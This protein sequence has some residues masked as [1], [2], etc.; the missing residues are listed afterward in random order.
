MKTKGITLLGL[1]PG[2]PQLLTLQAWEILNTV[3][4]IYLRTRLHLMVD[5]LPSTL[6]VHSFDHLFETNDPLDDIYTQIVARVLMLG[7][8]PEGIIYAVPGH[9]LIANTACLEILRSAREGGIPIRIVEGLSFL[10]P[11]CSA[12]GINPLPHTAVIDGLE[13]ADAHH[14]F[15]PPDQPVLIYQ[16][17]HSQMAARVK[18]TLR[19]VYPEDHSIQLVHG[20]GTDGQILEDLP[21]KMLDSSEHLGPLTTLYLPPLGPATSLESFQEIVAHLRAPNGCPWDREQTHQSL[22]PNLLEET[23][24]LVAALDDDDPA[25]MVEEFG[26]LLL[27]IILHAQIASERGNFNFADIVN[28]IHTKIVRRH[29]HVFGSL[30]L[31]DAESVIKNWEKL[32]AEERKINGDDKKGLLDGVANAMPSL[33]Q[34]E[35][36]QKRA[37]RV[38]FDWPDIQ[39]VLEKISEEIV[40]IHQSPTEAKR[41]DEFGDLLFALVNWARWYNIDAES[42]LRSTNRRFR[43]RFSYIEKIAR[44]QGRSM[45]ELSL[46]EMDAL[47]DEAKK[48][49]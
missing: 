44:E 45:G 25:A 4:E 27:Q 26:D 7:K 47:W 46:N 38:G 28:G 19:A 29:P 49:C 34:A 18:T 5:G 20:A 23:F 30:D 48:K 17:Q 31:G 13:L 1:G 16:I 32:K 12:L 6:Q 21:L 10:E 8:R 42:A 3:S 24:E 40:E 33:V 37:A 15:F 35:T 22:R 36:F 41:A 43:E 2:N 9:P 14:P 11:V 39:G